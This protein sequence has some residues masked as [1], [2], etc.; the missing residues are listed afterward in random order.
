[1]EHHPDLVSSEISNLWTS[2]MSDQLNLCLMTSF[3]DSS[4]DS[5]VKKILQQSKAFSEKNIK[6]I[7]ELF[8]KEKI[9]IPQG[10]S[11]AD[12]NE[13]APKLYSDIFYLRFLER[14]GRVGA[15][16][17]GMALGT[18]YREDVIDFYILN[19]NESSKLYKNVLN[20]M[21]AQ[22]V[23]VRSPYIPYPEKVEF[24][25][26]EHFF[27][28]VFTLHKRSLLAVELNH[29]ANNIE[30]NIV[31]RTLI[32]GFAQVAERKEVRDFFQQ[33]IKLSNTIINQLENVI[34]KNETNSPFTSSG[35]VTNSTI[36]PF[37]DKLMMAFVAGLNMISLENLGKGIAASMRNDLIMIYT[38]LIGQVGKYA[39]VGAKL[40]VNNGWVEKPPQTI[41]KR[42]L[43]DQQ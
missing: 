21:K 3:M 10:Y 15:S 23:L 29:L 20:L 36:A 33:G 43:Q 42:D 9:A 38:E 34:K 5:K 39:S 18:S 11:Q 25:Q 30:A 35:T 26:D 19:L 4:T 1:M 41:D 6:K 24:I 14:M 7:T 16:I 27:H 40:A 2:Y 12:V 22:G 28:G 32:E 13:K 31:G 8:N 17:N 37:S